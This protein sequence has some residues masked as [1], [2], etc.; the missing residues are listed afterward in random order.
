M[1]QLSDLEAAITAVGEALT[2]LQADVTAIIDKLK[3]GGSVPDADIAA[4]ASVATGIGTA[5]DAIE[6]AIN[7]PPPPVI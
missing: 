6:K 7:P 2:R 3:A 1:A 4:L 5:A